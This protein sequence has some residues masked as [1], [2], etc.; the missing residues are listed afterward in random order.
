M[1]KYTLENGL[2]IYFYQDSKK[3]SVSVNLVVKYGGTY[4]DFKVNNIKYHMQ[5]GVAHLMEHYVLEQNNYGNI[6][7]IFDKYHLDSNGITYANHTLFYFNGVKNIDEALEILIN[8]IH[9]VDFTLEK[10]NE[11]KPAVYEEIRMKK[12]NKGRRLVETGLENIFNSITYRSGLGTLEQVESI[13]KDDLELCYKS[14]YR[15]TN[16]FI[17][18]A[19]N[20]DEIKMLEKIKKLYDNLSFSNDLVKLIKIKEKNDIKNKEGKIIFPTVDPIIE[21]VFKINLSKLTNKEKLRL[22]F[23]FSYFIRMNFSVISPLYKE[24]FHQ[25]II[26]DSLFTNRTYLYNYMIFSVGAY[27]S[28]FDEFKKYIMK[29][30]EKPIFDEAI[31]NLEQKDSIL[32]MILRKERLGSMVFPFIENIVQF[33]YQ[34]LDTVNYIKK[35]NYDDFINLMSKLSFDDYTKTILIEQN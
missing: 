24:L 5:D 33:N 15:P 3:H 2:D 28:K 8:G 10:L 26:N 7:R 19:G 35:L 17:V 9:H 14:F 23:Y 1:K 29:T 27:T 12:D 25:K 20:F 18:I 13:T 4:S 30:V 16:E 32:D 34:H 22:D 11:V 6:M 31:F 21:I